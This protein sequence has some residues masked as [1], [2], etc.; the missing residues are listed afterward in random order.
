MTDDEACEHTPQDV[1]A[2][3]VCAECGEMLCADALCGWPKQPHAI[4]EHDEYPRA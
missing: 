4:N 1:R 2:G 3:T